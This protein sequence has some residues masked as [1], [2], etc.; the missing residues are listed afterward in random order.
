M[1]S[2]KC[3]FIS[4]GHLALYFFFSALRDITLF[5]GSLVSLFAMVGLLGSLAILGTYIVIMPISRT[6]KSKPKFAYVLAAV[7]IL[8]YTLILGFFLIGLKVFV[9]VVHMEQAIMISGNVGFNFLIIMIYDS[10]TGKPLKDSF[11]ELFRELEEL[12][13]TVGIPDDDPQRDLHP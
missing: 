4:I 8:L 2:F 13:N 12:D 9:S 7:A 6:T 5:S 11:N 1:R 3:C 10:M